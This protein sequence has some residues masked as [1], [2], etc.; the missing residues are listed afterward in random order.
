MLLSHSR[1]THPQPPMLPPCDHSAPRD[2]PGGGYISCISSNTQGALPED[3]DISIR[4]AVT[5]VR[6]LICNTSSC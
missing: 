5:P 6:G 3:R 1:H 2:E 4:S